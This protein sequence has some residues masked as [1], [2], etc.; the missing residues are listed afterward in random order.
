MTACSVQRLLHV[1]IVVADI[2]QAVDLYAGFLGLN[3]A[4]EVVIDNVQKVKV[5]FMDV[6][7]QVGLELIE[8]LTDESPVSK[9]AQRGGGLHHLC[10]EVENIDLAVKTVRE[11]GAVVVC[12]PVAAP[13]FNSRRI[14]FA[15]VPRMG[16]IEFVEA[17]KGEQTSVR[18]G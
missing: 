5:V 2:R 18:S 7:N 1:G 12:E 16:L 17:V 9:F 4:S 15:Y 14:A 8:P 13:A 6:G 3:L 11:K 10:Y